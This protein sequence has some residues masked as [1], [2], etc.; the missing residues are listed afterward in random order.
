[1]AIIHQA[2]LKAFTSHLQAKGYSQKS[3]LNYIRVYIK[4]RTWIAEQSLKI[5]E[6]GYSDAMAYIQHLQTTNVKSITVQRYIGCLKI[7]FNYWVD[8]KLIEHNPIQQFNL[9]GVKRK[10]TYNVLSAEE[11]E[12]VYKEFNQQVDSKKQY[13]QRMI[14]EQTLCLQRDKVILGLLIYQ[15]L[16][17]EELNILELSH[18]DLQQ[19][20]ITIPEGRRRS[21]R[22]LKLESHQVIGFYEY[23]NNT[24]KELLTCKYKR[25][26]EYKKEL[27]ENITNLFISH[28]AGLELN[29]LLHKLGKQLQT[30]Y[31]KVRGL[32]HIRASVIVHWLNQHNKRKVQQMAGHRYIS[33]TENYESSNMADLQEDF[34]T[35]FPILD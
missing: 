25:A 22:T 30:Q 27:P 7:I 10:T 24:R 23:I 5:E 19:G 16:K 35:F 3:R 28:D 31:P 8:T 2:Q 21:E 34:N 13:S 20:T 11:L 4:F 15:G 14:K 17:A 32:K 33:S 26:T 1:M 6:L 29:N 9:K 18:L 12:Q